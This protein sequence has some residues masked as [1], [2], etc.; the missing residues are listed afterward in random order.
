MAV[1]NESRLEKPDSGEALAGFSGAAIQG[2]AYLMRQLFGLSHFSSF[3]LPARVRERMPPACS[4]RCMPFPSLCLATLIVFV[5]TYMLTQ[6]LFVLREARSW[7]VHGGWINGIGASTYWLFPA[8][9]NT[10]YT[11][12]L[13]AN[14]LGKTCGVSIEC[15]N[16]FQSGLVALG[17][18]AVLI[19]SFQLL[20][21]YRL[22]LFAA[23]L[24]VM[25][26]PMLSASI[27]QAVQHDKLATI[28]SILIL[29][30]S[31]EYF[32]RAGGSRLSAALFS[33][34]LTV[35]LGVAFNAKEST[36]ILP[37]CIT[38]LAIT[39]SVKA[40]NNIRQRLLVI[41]LPMVYSAWYI[42]Y[43][44]VH[45]QAQWSQHIASGSP[46][47]GVRDLFL[48]LLNINLGFLPGWG[49]SNDIAILV[50]KAIYIMFVV[51]VTVLLLVWV[52]GERRVKTGS[53]SRMP[54]RVFLY[55]RELYTLAIFV[56]SVAVVVRTRYP[57][58]YYMIIPS[59]AGIVLTIMVLKRLASK[60][61]PGSLLFQ[62]LLTSLAVPMLISY[63]THF[64]PGGGVSRLLQGSREIESSFT[65]VRSL[66]PSDK[67]KAVRLTISGTPYG[68]WL[69]LWGRG[70]EKLDSDLGPYIFNDLSVHPLMIDGRDTLNQG[71]GP[72]SEAQ[73]TP[74]GEAEITLSEE[75]RLVK[76]SFGGTLVFQ[77][78]DH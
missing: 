12:M 68:D 16:A 20:G 27:W 67:V 40:G 25:S 59:W 39:L 73:L 15:T 34:V 60:F 77:G 9:S 45:L 78:A 65:A 6:N 47:G 10:R 1:L 62:A 37:F 38:F 56:I 23:S 57:G 2:D 58:A 49:V 31:V 14:F 36:F 5:C 64:F 30:L 29:A 21:T 8:G 48:F 35:L 33:A 66:L 22:S 11:S 32:S 24:W 19:H 7:F 28:L 61:D 51:F 44:L 63:S 72:V 75:Y 70:E 18:A 53:S 4:V 55:W 3:G 50:A 69:L 13:F 43:Y 52:A 46:L 74:Q 42:T 54:E 17:F 41:A 26:S 71:R 76:V